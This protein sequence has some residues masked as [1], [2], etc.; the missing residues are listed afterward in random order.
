M[1]YIIDIISLLRAKKIFS[2]KGEYK[3]MPFY[4]FIDTYNL[5]NNTILNGFR[6]KF[7]FEDNYEYMYLYEFI[8]N[9]TNKI[10]F[11]IS[12]KEIIRIPDNCEIIC[13]YYYHDNFIVYADCDDKEIN[14]YKYHLLSGK[15]NP[16]VFNTPI[17]AKVRNKMEA[18]MLIRKMYNAK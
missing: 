1:K 11:S 8:C 4:K 14:F 12:D 9:K 17:N 16:M 5:T 2:S 13:H 7:I 3:Y 10:L 15:F 6:Y 18:Y